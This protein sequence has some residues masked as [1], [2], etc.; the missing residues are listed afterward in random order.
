M[1]AGRFGGR[2]TLLTEPLVV[3]LEDELF[4]N[5]F[6]VGEAAVAVGVHRNT[7]TNWFRRYPSLLKRLQTSYQKRERERMRIED[8][9]S[10]EFFEE[11]DRKIAQAKKEAADSR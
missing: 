6:L 2:P 3:R 11:I 10:Y 1:K 8:P 4:E 9:E 5:G 7:L